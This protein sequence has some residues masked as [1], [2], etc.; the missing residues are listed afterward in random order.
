MQQN[1]YFLSVWLI[2]RSS[3]WV[4]KGESSLHDDNANN[5]ESIWIITEGA[6]RIPTPL[7]AVEL[8][9]PHSYHP[10]QEWSSRLFSAPLRL[11]SVVER[12]G[13]LDLGPVYSIAWKKEQG[14]H[15]SE[16]EAKKQRVGLAFG[17]LSTELKVP[18]VYHRLIYRPCLSWGQWCSPRPLLM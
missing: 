2:S 1:F 5:G 6:V 14:S 7:T 12:G 18:D 16:Q 4:M 3:F 10:A 8:T 11:L 15:G 17:P 13:I 9:M